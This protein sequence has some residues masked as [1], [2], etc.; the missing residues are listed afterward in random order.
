MTTATAVV[1]DI[2][3]ELYHVTAERRRRMGQRV[4]VFDPFNLTG[5]RQRDGL[6][7]LDQFALGVCDV[8][9]D[10]QMISPR[11]LSCGFEFNTDPFWN[12]MGTSL[13]SGII[14][15]LVTGAKPEEKNLDASS[16]ATC[17]PTTSFTIWRFCSIRAPSRARRPGGKSRP[18]CSCPKKRASR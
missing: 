10:S 6:N 2:K 16:S 18:R 17:F 8:E 7:P 1:V 12:T 14:S 15:H 11:N 3:G 13:G 5:G 9:S 4:Y